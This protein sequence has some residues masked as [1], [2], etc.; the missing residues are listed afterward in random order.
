MGDTMQTLQRAVVVQRNMSW[1]VKPVLWQEN[2]NTSNRAERQARVVQSCRERTS[3][4]GERSSG[5]DDR[6]GGM[7]EQ[8][9]EN[10]LFRRTPV[11]KS[12]F[13][14]FFFFAKRWVTFYFAT[15]LLLFPVSG[16]RWA[17]PA[18]EI[19]SRNQGSIL[20]N[21]KFLFLT[22]GIQQKDLRVS[23]YIPE[24]R[25]LLSAGQQHMVFVML[26]STI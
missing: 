8:R 10:S 1:N 5:K 25:P 11:S 26:K 4:D 2:K 3:S 7:C 13:L 15:R 21:Y 17:E 22:T 20:F 16:W 9:L 24:F 12:F 23:I 18:H 14:P 6:W 19:T